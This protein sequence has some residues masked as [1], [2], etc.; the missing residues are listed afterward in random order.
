[1]VPYFMSQLT[2][3]KLPGFGSKAGRQLSDRGVIQASDALRYT[4]AELVAWLGEKSGPLLYRSCRGIDHSIVMDKGPPRSIV[5]QM[6]LY[7]IA[8]SDTE[9]LLKITRSLCNDIA[10]RVLCDHEE[11]GRVPR[12]LIVLWRL[13][14]Q[15]DTSKSLSMPHI[16]DGVA[17]DLYD[18][19]SHL[20]ALT[21]FAHTTG[22]CTRLALTAANFTAATTTTTTA[23][24]SVS[25]NSIDALWKRNTMATQSRGVLNSTTLSSQQDAAAAGASDCVSVV[26][27]DRS[28]FSTGSGAATRSSFASVMSVSRSQPLVSPKRRRVPLSTS[29]VSPRRSNAADATGVVNNGL[30]VSTQDSNLE[31]PSTADSR[32]PQR[33]LCE[34]DCTTVILPTDGRRCE[35]CGTVV[36]QMESAV[37]QHLDWHVAQRLEAELNGRPV[38]DRSSAI[39]KRSR[40]KPTAA[41]TASRKQA[42]TIDSFFVRK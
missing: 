1:M 24:G 4:E 6:S 21:V 27:D 14:G 36:P 5:A 42:R 26:A 3:R 8:C 7:P 18:C 35:Q 34:E 29:A 10:E 17:S 28:Q 25:C 40:S 15:V 22:H 19:V 41:A 12:S 37:Q 13:Q 31:W 2:A 32:Q 38:S 11:Y 20:L 9:P 30:A 23:S 33:F 39:V 16:R